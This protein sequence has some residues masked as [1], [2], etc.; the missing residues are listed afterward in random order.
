MEKNKLVLSPA[1][2]KIGI[3]SF[4]LLGI[5]NTMK[6]AKLFMQGQWPT[7][8]WTWFESIMGP[9]WLFLAIA[10]YLRLKQQRDLPKP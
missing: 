2:L 8:Y 1:L 3:A 10:F 4:G 9:I 6:L 7:D 5:I